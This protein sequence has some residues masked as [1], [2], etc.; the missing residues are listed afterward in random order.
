M[1]LSE[2][3]FHSALQACMLQHIR[4]CEL[5]RAA[6]AAPT[7]PSPC[8]SAVVYKQNEQSKIGLT[9]VHCGSYPAGEWVR[10]TSGEAQWSKGDL[11][12]LLV[13]EG[14][15]WMAE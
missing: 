10:C 6:Q 9:G 13:E 11:I 14:R 15:C 5:E 1:T 3:T 4:Q 8:P 12:G 7:L 2:P